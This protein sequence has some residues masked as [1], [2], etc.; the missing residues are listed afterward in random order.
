MRKALGLVVSLTALL[1][2]ACGGG[3]DS[4]TGPSQGACGVLGLSTR[5]GLRIVNGTECSEENSPVVALLLATPDGQQGLCSGSVVGPTAVLTAAHCFFEGPDRGVVSVNNRRYTISRVEV[6]PNVEVRQDVVINDVAIVFTSTPIDAPLLPLVLSRQARSGDIMQI[7]GYG[8]VRGDT[9][10]DA[11][12]GVLRSG[13][14][15]I[16]SVSADLLYAKFGNEGSNTC[17]GD[18]GGPAVLQV[19]N[20]AGII[21]L[22]SSGALE[23]CGRGDVSVFANVQSQEIQEFILRNVP[24]IPVL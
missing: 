11:G 4:D 22:T 17:F 2:T 6:H 10:S 21:G 18:S 5:D 16:D 20:G 23:N 19:G 9:N 13:E 8:Q 14:M 24:G 1:L 3:S 7:Y 15:E 12:M